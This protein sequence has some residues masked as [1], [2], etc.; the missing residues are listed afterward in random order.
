MV[1]FSKDNWQQ[2]FDEEQF[3]Q[4]LQGFE[5]GFTLEQIA[6]YAD[7]KFNSIQMWEARTGLKNGLTMEQVAVYAGVRN[8]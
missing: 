3:K 1:D 8:C 6:I 2:E 4:I 5:A 7:P